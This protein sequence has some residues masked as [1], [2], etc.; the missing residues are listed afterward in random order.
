MKKLITVIAVV[1]VFGFAVA[2]ADLVSEQIVSDGSQHHGFHSNLSH[3]DQLYTANDFMGL[4]YF[5]LSAYA[6]QNVVGDGTMTLYYWQV[7]NYNPT[8]VIDIHQVNAYNADANMTTCTSS[9]RG[10]GP[11]LDNGG[12]GMANLHRTAV[13]QLSLGILDSQS[14]VNPAEQQP[15]PFTIPEAAIQDWLDGTT[16]SLVAVVCDN[17]HYDRWDEGLLG[18]SPLLNPKIEFET[19]EPEPVIPEPAGLGLVGLALLGLRRRR[20]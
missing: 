16:P 6:G 20:S 14:I 3:N 2:Q 9:S 5:D 8:P 15:F 7:W 18:G 11:W 13:P 1:A 19:G 4:V 12:A 10:P 17:G